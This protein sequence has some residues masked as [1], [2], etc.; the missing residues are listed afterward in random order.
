MDLPAGGPEL[1][2]EGTIVTVLRS[3]MFRVRLPD[4]GEIVAHLAGRLRI[5]PVRL[6]PGDHVLVQVSRYDPSRGRIL[7]RL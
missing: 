2:Q 4:G 6:L 1:G 3:S 5:L 7:E